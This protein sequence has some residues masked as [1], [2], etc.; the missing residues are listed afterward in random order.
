MNTN[1]ALRKKLKP[2]ELHVEVEDH[3]MVGGDDSV[4]DFLKP[5]ELHVEVEDHPMVGGPDSVPDFLKPQE[6]HVEV[7]DH[8]MV[9]G[10]DSVPDFL[11]PQ[12][13]HVEVEDY[14]KTE[15]D[16]FDYSKE[17][18]LVGG[19]DSLPLF[20]LKPRAKRPKKIV[21]LKDRKQSINGGLDSLPPFLRSG[22]NDSH[23]HSLIQD[24]QMVGGDDSIPEAK[25]PKYYIQRIDN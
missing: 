2:Q 10:D 5:Q 4:P 3:P 16:T 14:P 20:L 11:K 19:P 21:N 12:E 8:P 24:H 17:G 9:G 7:Q 25:R 15:V 23:P 13:L 18:E 6:L 1:F 22:Y